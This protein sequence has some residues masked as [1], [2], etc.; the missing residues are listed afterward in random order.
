MKQSINIAKGDE[1]LLFTVAVGDYFVKD[2]FELFEGSSTQK[3]IDNL[4]H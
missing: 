2:T 4:S 3:D 1:G